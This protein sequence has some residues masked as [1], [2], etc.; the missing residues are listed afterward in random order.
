M[1]E[2]ELE[3]EDNNETGGWKS[4]LKT[5]FSVACVLGFIFGWI[6]II[7]HIMKTIHTDESVV[8]FSLPVGGAMTVIFVSMGLG[9]LTLIFFILLKNTLLR[10]YSFAEIKKYSF[11]LLI[12]FIAYVIVSS[13]FLFFA[14]DNYI[15]VTKDEVG[16][17][18]FWAIGDGKYSWDEGVKNITLDYSYAD[19]GDTSDNFSGKYTFHLSDDKHVE[20][21][22]NSLDGNF[23]SIEKI[24][25]IALMHDVTYNVISAPSDE[26]IEKWIPEKHQ[27]F[28]KEL[29][30]K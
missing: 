12:G 24:N 19:M 29:F 27:E 6:G 25:D 2:N 22:E 8:Y 28:V 16:Y 30:S 15:Y 20:I 9:I 21:W 4:K 11:E 14:I 10:K 26:N 3:M 5:A 23:E 17:S 7:R 18:G 13:P 1:Q